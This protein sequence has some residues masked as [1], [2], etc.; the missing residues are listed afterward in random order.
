MNSKPALVFLHGHGV[1]PQIWDSLQAALGDEYQI[2]KPDFSTLTNHTTVEAYAEQ[3][4]SMLVSTQITRCVLIGHSMGGYIALA[5]A[6][7]HP[8]LVAG[9]ILFNSTAFADPD[10][11]EQRAKRQAAQEQLKTEGGAAFV[12]KAVTTMFSMPNQQ[13]KPDLVRQTVDRYES[14]PTE[15]LLAGLEAIRSRP[16]RSA[17]LASAP[18]PVLIVAGHH[19]L[20]IPFERTQELKAKL[21]NATMVVLESSGHAGMLEEPE[22][23]QEALKQ[24]LMY[25]VQ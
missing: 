12:E 14:L 16:D 24:F 18:Y 5:L 13:R 17:M 3:L 15:A 8:N 4:Y 20:A 25:S 9:L 22:K 2:I 1:G 11:D 10:T 7:A 19:D 23:A 6:A 21:P